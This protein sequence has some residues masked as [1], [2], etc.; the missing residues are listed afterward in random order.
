MRQKRTA[1]Q[2]LFDPEP[3]HHPVAD[4]LKAISAWL[5]AH[6]EL[7]D[8]ITADLGAAA[9]GR[10]GLSCETV[11]RCAVL[12][13]LRQETWRGL[14]FTLRDS[15]S[16]RRFVRADPARLPKKS[17]LQAGL[18]GAAR[19]REPMKIRIASD[20]HLEAREDDL[21]AQESFRSDASRDVLILAGD[22]RRYLLARE[23]VF[24]ELALTPVTDVPGNHEYY[25]LQNRATVD[26]L[27]RLPCAA[28]P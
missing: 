1:Q 28:R 15:A 13:H 24:R 20:L 11:L 2:S 3:V 16:A 10:T 17:A 19:R 6:P 25:G 7:L 14:E 8:T 12:K 22:I 23:F 27:H 26:G 18:E 9:C 21:P 5:D 4:A